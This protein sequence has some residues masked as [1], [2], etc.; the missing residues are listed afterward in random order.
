MAKVDPNAEI[1][2]SGAG[3]ITGVGYGDTSGKEQITITFNAVYL[4]LPKRIT[5]LSLP[6]R[7][8]YHKLPKRRTYLQ[9]TAH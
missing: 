2:P 7:T 6:K 3:G 4:K 1:A 8:T 5:Y 9:L